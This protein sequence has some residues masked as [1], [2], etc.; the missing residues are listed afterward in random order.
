MEQ[1]R[2]QPR[3][4]PRRSGGRS[5]RVVEAVLNAACDELAD[6]G[7]AAFSVAAVARRAGVHETSIYRRW[8]TREALALA[9]GRHA[10]HTEEEPPD[11][12]GLRQDL[13]DLALASYDTLRSGHGRV[14]LQSCLAAEPGSD[15]YEG[16]LV[17]WRHRERY[18]G[19]IFERA[20]ARGEWPAT[21]PWRPVSDML[22]GA[23][24]YRVVVT[25]EEVDRRYVEGL[26]DLLDLGPR[27]GK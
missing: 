10:F 19:K 23:M 13:V 20:A 25:K 26:L 2:E 22:L 5:A 1:T 9:A 11:R 17:N 18:L 14:I 3:E 12:G 24:H 6:G 7:L 8:K 4:K 15:E 21:R 16:V 27:P